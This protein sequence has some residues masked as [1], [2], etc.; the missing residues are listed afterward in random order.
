MENLDKPEKPTNEELRDL[1]WNFP[2]EN[3]RWHI[4]AASALCFAA[5]CMWGACWGFGRG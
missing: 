4:I 5:G 1:Y 2:V 3:K